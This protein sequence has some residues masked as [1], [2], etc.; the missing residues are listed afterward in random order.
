MERGASRLQPADG[1]PGED[2][3]PRLEYLGAEALSAPA[4]L[5]LS[6]V[7]LPQAKY[8]T[9]LCHNYSLAGSCRW[10]AQCCF[11]HGEEELRAG[12]Q[13]GAKF[14]LKPCA[15]FNSQSFCSYGHRCQYIHRF[16]YAESLRCFVER[17]CAALSE[18]P[19]TSLNLLLARSQ[20]SHPPLSIFRRLKRLF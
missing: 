3:P 12:A 11:A 8:K 9:E 2:A 17:A 16:S 4:S 6:Q 13:P 19:Q 20:L 10:R 14:K 18:T 1:L 15:K 7:V 5:F